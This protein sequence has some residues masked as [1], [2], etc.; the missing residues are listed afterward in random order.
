MG[1]RAAGPRGQMAH[2]RSVLDAWPPAQT[3]EE[4]QLTLEQ[5]GFEEHG[6][7]STCLFFFPHK[8]CECTFCPLCVL[9]TLSSSLLY[10]HNAGY[11]PCNRQKTC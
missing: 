4:I 5:H 11:H 8:Y 9:K 1:M 7:T 3:K 2:A 10:R 6:S